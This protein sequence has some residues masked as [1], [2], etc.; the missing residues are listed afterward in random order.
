MRPV[1]ALVK[2]D[3]PLQYTLESYTTGLSKDF[4]GDRTIF[5]LNQ[6]RDLS[7]LYCER[8]GALCFPYF[9][10]PVRCL[11]WSKLVFVRCAYRMCK[12]IC[13]SD[14]MIINFASFNCAV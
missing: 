6:L 4:F 14:S 1:F 5:S 9:L 13:F 8:S 10:C 11:A 3:R 7:A 2:R 12:S